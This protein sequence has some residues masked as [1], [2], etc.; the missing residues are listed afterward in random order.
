MIISKRDVQR[1]LDTKE[2]R[3][4]EAAHLSKLTIAQLAYIA[5]LFDGEGSVIIS[6][7]TNGS[8]DARIAVA[9]TC[10]TTIKWLHQLLNGGLSK[11]NKGYHKIVYKWQ[12]SR[13]L[14]AEILKLLLPYLITKQ[15]QAKLFIEF[16]ELGGQMLGKE[17]HFE[18]RMEIVQLIPKLNRTGTE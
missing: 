13:Y 8:V 17:K 1:W 4:K 10:E 12:A 7:P 6:T 18:R 9:M 5:G 2:N 14:G 16:V 15:L 3:A 11:H